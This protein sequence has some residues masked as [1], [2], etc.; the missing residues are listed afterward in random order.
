MME[1]ELAR[2][3]PKP[4]RVFSDGTGIPSS[5]DELRIRQSQA[6]VDPALEPD[7]SAHHGQNKSKVVRFEGAA[8]VQ[9]EAP[10]QASDVR[11][12]VR[13]QGT[14][15]RSAI[16][17]EGEAFDRNAQVTRAAD[18]TLSSK[19]SLLKQTGEQVKEDASSMIDDAGRA[20]KNA[21]RK[22]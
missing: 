9:R 1:A 6:V 20:I 11:S 17:A 13:D 10:Q 16:A 12:A 15:V 5:F 14:H 21:L 7:V 19:R 4:N 2:Q 3:S 18:G 22:E 8:Q